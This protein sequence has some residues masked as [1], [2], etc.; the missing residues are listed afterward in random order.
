MR[1]LRPLLWLAG[2]VGGA[3]R[4][5]RA[6]RLTEVPLR[7]GDLGGWLDEVTVE[8]AVVELARWLGIVLAAT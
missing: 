3:G 2:G 5:R 8:V 4:V 6:G 1:V 7:W